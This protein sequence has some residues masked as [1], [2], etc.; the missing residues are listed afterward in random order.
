MDGGPIMLRELRSRAGRQHVGPWQLPLNRRKQVVG[1]AIG[2]LPERQRVILA[3][4]YCDGLGVRELADA[5]QLTPREVNRAI[6]SGVSEV[7]RTLMR[8][9]LTARAAPTTGADP[10]AR[11]EGPR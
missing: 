3:L 8:A 1:E 4:R 5:M 7:Y 10:G 11:A 2:G 6:S 9:E